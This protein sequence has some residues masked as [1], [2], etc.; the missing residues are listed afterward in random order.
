MAQFES[1]L[2]SNAKFNDKESF[3][4]GD[5]LMQLQD[6]VDN[7]K[8]ELTGGILQLEISD[9]DIAKLVGQSLREIQRYIDE[10]VLIQ[11][12]FAPCIDLTDF[13]HSSITNV[14]RT[15]LVGDIGSTSNGGISSVDPMYAQVWMAYSNGGSMYNLNN[16]LMN[17]MTYNTLLQLRN[18]QST[19]MAFREDKHDN[20]LYINA[21]SGRPTEVVIEYV[22]V[23]SDVSEVKSDYWIDILQR[24]SLALTKRVLGR[25]RTYAKQ[26]N[27]LYTIDGDTLL[28]EGNNELTELREVL[29]NNSTLFYPVD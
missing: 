8:L 26:S 25:I 1:F 3:D 5:D 13:K 27:A 19:D 9:D 24:H 21:S 28:E 22:P 17:Y 7:I 4:F 15:D 6:Y 14:Y 23:F 16:Y 29:R 2:I 20:K 12:P 11:V 18:T 10:T